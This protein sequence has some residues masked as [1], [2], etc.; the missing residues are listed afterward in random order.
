M[1]AHR[2]DTGTS[3]VTMTWNNTQKQYLNLWHIQLHQQYKII[4]AA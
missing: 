1:W 2:I 4:D 3:F